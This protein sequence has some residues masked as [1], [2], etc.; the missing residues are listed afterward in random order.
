MTTD[1]R[2]GENWWDAYPPPQ[3]TPAVIPRET[4]MSWLQSP[5]KMPGKDYLIVD[6]RRIDH[7]VLPKVFVL[8]IGRLNQTFGQLSRTVVVSFSSGCVGIG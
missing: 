6:V 4:V 2:R 1:P 5:D 3:S 8:T 7:T